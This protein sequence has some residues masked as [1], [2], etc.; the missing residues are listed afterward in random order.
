MDKALKLKN[1]ETCMV[2]ALALV[3]AFLFKP[4]ILFLC[5]AIGLGLIGLFVPVLAN[6]IRWAWFGL[7]EILGAITSKILLALIFFLF[8]TPIALLYRLFHKKHLGQGTDKTTYWISRA[9][10]FGPKDLE[11]PW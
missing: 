7:A 10:R 2:L 8:L 9:Y 11:N 1:L 5:F 4:E 3:I 6:A